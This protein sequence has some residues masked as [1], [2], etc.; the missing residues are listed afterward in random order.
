MNGV[1]VFID[2]IKAPRPEQGTVKTGIEGPLFLFIRIIYLNA[3]NS[4]FPLSLSRGPSL[5]KALAANL[6]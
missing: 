5:I 1:S 3:T 6:A 2:L 4:S